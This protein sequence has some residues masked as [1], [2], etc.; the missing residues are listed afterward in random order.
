MNILIIFLALTANKPNDYVFISAIKSPARW[1]SC[2][3]VTLRVE[4]GYLN[5]HG[6][7]VI[8]QI[9]ESPTANAGRQQF[10]DFW[11][12][13]LNKPWY[14]RE[15]VYEY[16]NG[17]LIPG[18]FNGNEHFV[19]NVGGTVLTM[20]QYVKAM[21][22]YGLNLH[23]LSTSP[24]SY[25]DRDIEM[26]ESLRNEPIRRIYNLPGKFVKQ[27]ELPNLFPMLKLLKGSAK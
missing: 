25:A 17:M 2:D 11:D 3:L 26:T 6:D 20:S 13:Y 21:N 10:A 18:S 7:F 23:V 4:S 22:A 27:K 14:L 8:D 16:R 1:K 15:P 9:L 19:P 5:K 12:H 24:G